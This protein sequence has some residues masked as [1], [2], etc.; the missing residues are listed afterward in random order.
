MSI[1]AASPA[2]RGQPPASTPATQPQPRAGDGR[3]VPERVSKDQVTAALAVMGLTFTDAQIEMLMPTANRLF[4]QYEALRKVDIPL[5]TPPAVTFS[6][7]IAGFPT[8]HG[9]SHF[10]HGRAPALI[11]YKN[12][13]ELAFLSALELG[14]MVRSRRITSAALTRMYLDRLKTYAPKLNCVITL[15]EDLALDQA[16]HADRLLRR[17]K[18]LSAVH[19]VPYGAKDLF[20][21][22]GILT[23]WGAEPYQHRV[24]DSDATVIER[25]RAAGTPL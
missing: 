12:P 11:R 1:L 17:G 8:P 4:A 22:K 21:T 18:R 23:S 25:L 15:T 20:D 7:V 9:S 16:A 3:P 13:E 5:D 19:G 6:P 10:R 14:A 24:P 2:L